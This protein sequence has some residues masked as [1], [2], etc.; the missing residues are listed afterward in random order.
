MSYSDEE[1]NNFLT[2]AQE[3]GI[4]KAKRELGYPKSWSTGQY[5][6]KNRGVTVAVDEVMAKAKST[7]EWYKT[8]EVITIAQE[9]MNRVWDE[10]LNNASLLP[11]DQK[12]LAEAFQKYTNVWLTAQ[13]K[14]ANITESRDTDS[15]DARIA[16]MLEAER[17]RNLTKKE[18]ATESSE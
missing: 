15:F 16:E 3:V 11:D 7:D 4:T 6:A 1:I 2:L 9:G 10:L 17:M 18:N 13:G 12:K 5:W 8:E 14:A